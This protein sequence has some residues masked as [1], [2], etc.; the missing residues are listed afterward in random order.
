MGVFEALEFHP[1]WSKVPNIRIER[2]EVENLVAAAKR[3]GP[4]VGMR[5]M[6]RGHD[7]DEFD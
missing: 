7:K 3:A 2:L 1:H 6:R 5:G 4:E